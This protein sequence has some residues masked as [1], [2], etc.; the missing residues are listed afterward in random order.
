MAWQVEELQLEGRLLFERD[1][2]MVCEIRDILEH[3]GVLGLR[4][5]VPD[6]VLGVEHPLLAHIH[7]NLEY[8]LQFVDGADVV[9]MAMRQ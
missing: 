5:E 4:R 1:D 9:E 6:G 3:D 8:R 7:G 2:S